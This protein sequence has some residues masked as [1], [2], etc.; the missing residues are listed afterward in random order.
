M[1]YIT[2]HTVTATTNS[3]GDVTAYTTA[4]VNGKLLAV[5]YVKTDYADGIDVDITL[6]SSGLALLSVDDMNA[7]VTYY[8]RAELHDTAGVALTYDG[9]EPVPDTLP[10]GNERIKVIVASGGNTKT[11]T[12]YFYVEGN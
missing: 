5:R 7:S 2:R 1:S 11:G 3:D 10:I 4:C 6:E 8:P 12:F 9:T